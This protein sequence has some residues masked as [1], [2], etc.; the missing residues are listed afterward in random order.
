MLA[1]QVYHPAHR[2][3]D[4]LGDAR[5][6]R[7]AFAADFLRDRCPCWRLAFA[8]DFLRDRCPETGVRALGCGVD[9]GNLNN[10]GFFGFS[11]QAASAP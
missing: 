10:P 4:P 1:P 2:P 11:V 5:S 7:R 9:Y 3:A 8:A 6:Q